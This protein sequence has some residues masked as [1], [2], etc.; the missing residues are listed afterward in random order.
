MISSAYE[1]REAVRLVVSCSNKQIALCFHLLSASVFPF[2]SLCYRTLCISISLYKLLPTILLCEEV[3][4]QLQII[5]CNQTITLF[6]IPSLEKTSTSYLLN[7]GI[8]LLLQLQLFFMKFA[9]CYF[10]FHVQL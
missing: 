4:A 2:L 6:Y 5:Y 7:I 8:V 9:F 10:H 1:S 3:K